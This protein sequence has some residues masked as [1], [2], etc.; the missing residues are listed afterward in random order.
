METNT[1]LEK[2][3]RKP[4]MII[5]KTYLR[6]YIH[7]VHTDTDPLNSTGLTSLTLTLLSTDAQTHL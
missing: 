4:G 7:T 3:K 5:I 6:V 1:S 2:K